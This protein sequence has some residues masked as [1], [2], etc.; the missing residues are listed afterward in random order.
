MAL[1]I[2]AGV[3]AEARGMY[4]VALGD[5][6]KSIGAYQVVVGD[7]L[8]LPDNYTSQM[9]QQ[10]LQQVNANIE[11][12]EATCSQGYGP[13]DFAEKAKKALTPFINRIEGLIKELQDKERVEAEKKEA[14]EKKVD[15]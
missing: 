7:T 4:C 3:G 15:A 8:S 13:K 10:F 14:Q 12:Y 11:V 1:C 2:A 5:G 6:C 9:Y